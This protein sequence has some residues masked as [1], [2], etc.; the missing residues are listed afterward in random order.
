MANTD[1]AAIGRRAS[2]EWLDKVR[3]MCMTIESWCTTIMGTF[4][5]CVNRIG[6]AI[7]NNEKLLAEAQK[8]LANKKKLKLSKSEVKALQESISKYSKEIKHCKHLKKALNEK[9]RPY[10]GSGTKTGSKIAGKVFQRR[11]NRSVFFN[12]LPCCS[13]LVT[14]N[15]NIFIR[16]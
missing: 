13:V 14:Y 6:K 15:V 10:I 3:N 5:D 12:K 16:I 8:A 1:A 9:V 4:D 11:F 2:G 7:A